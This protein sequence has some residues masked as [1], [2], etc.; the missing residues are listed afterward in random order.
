LALPIAS[1]WKISLYHESFGEKK[2]RSEGQSETRHG[3][4]GNYQTA[5]KGMQF[6]DIGLLLI[7]HWQM[8]KKI[9]KKKTDWTQTY[10][11]TLNAGPRTRCQTLVWGC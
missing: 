8:G 2:L 7:P 3:D 9:Q 5:D 6:P 11:S 1:T 4:S 10:S